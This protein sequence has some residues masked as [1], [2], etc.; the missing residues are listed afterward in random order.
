[1]NRNGIIVLALGIIAMA[2][3]AYNIN[4]HTKQVLERIDTLRAEIADERER[5]QVLHVEWAYLNAPDRLARLAARHNDVLGLGPIA[6]EQLRDGTAVPF[7]P[8][9]APAP[10]D[11]P[12]DPV[13]VPVAAA[14][15]VPLP[16]VRP[17]SLATAGPG[18]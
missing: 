2:A 8:R 12:S 1:M 10:V 11:V 17:V 3:W 6:P 7:A 5:A 13:E 16:P 14:P 15:P 9:E 4:Y 18:G